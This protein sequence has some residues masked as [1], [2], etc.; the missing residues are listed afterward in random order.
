[1]IQI[2]I[3]TLFVFAFFKATDKDRIVDGFTSLAFVL[4]PALIIML[5]TAVMFALEA[6]FWAAHLLHLLYFFIPMILLK[7]ITRHSWGKSAVLA[8][9]VLLIVTMTQVLVAIAI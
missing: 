7:N 4:A 6:P 2:A 1:M 8:I 3:S 5:L 9:I